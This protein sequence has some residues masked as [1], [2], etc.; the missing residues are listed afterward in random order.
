[1]S[2][3]HAVLGPSSSSRWLNCTGS[4]AFIQTLELEPEVPGRPSMEGTYCHVVMENLIFNSF[5][6]A[7]GPVGQEALLNQRE[8]AKLDLEAGRDEFDLD[9]MVADLDGLIQYLYQM[10]IKYPDL[11]IYVEQKVTLEP[12][13]PDVWGTAD[14]IIYSPEASFMR[15]VDLKYGR[16]YVEE[17]HNPQLTLYFIGALL[18][19]LKG[20]GF[21]K[22]AGIIVYQPRGG[23]GHLREWEVGPYY[24][25]DFVNQKLNVALTEMNADGEF[26]PG[27]WC[28][29]C[30]GLLAC[31]PA[32]E[33]MMKVATMN[34]EPLEDD[35]AEAAELKEQETLQE[36]LG[37][38]K[39]ILALIDKAESAA[40]SRLALGKPLDGWKLVEGRTNRKWGATDDEI[41]TYLRTEA[42]LKL[43][44]VQMKKVIG[45]GAAEKLVKASKHGDIEALQA[46]ITK[47]AGAPT[48]APESDKRPAIES[49]HFE[50]I[51]DT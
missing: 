39:L 51:T 27:D 10:R 20:A 29:Y 40:V 2:H 4:P 35:N 43:K 45:I 32:R 36:I 9:Q 30:P 8:Q 49:N 47:P 25:R 14:I 22:D 6:V 26:R 41:I 46:Y 7:P 5:S 23:G 17:K 18:S 21:P 48:L 31:D 44:D 1:M 34:F 38:K 12:I 15:V 28:E 3:G 24:I 13:T 19:T 11:Q 42:K 37:A 16:V 33:K 50:D